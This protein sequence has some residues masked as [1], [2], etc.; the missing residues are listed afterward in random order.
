MT[1]ILLPDTEAEIEAIVH[2]AAQSGS[3]LA[4]HGGGTRAIGGHVHAERALS[5]QQ[6]SGITLYEPSELRATR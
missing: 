3:A 2:E 1:S 4:I 5:L 6:M